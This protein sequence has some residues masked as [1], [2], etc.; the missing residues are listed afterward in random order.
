MAVASFEELVD[1]FLADHVLPFLKC[2]WSRHKK[3][4]MSFNPRSSADSAAGRLS[5]RDISL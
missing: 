3:I 5:L 1:Q 2:C 4:L